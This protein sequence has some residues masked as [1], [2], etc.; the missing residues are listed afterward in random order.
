MN[1]L[2]IYQKSFDTPDYSNSE[3]YQYY[4]VLSILQNKY[5]KN[6]TFSVIDIGSG[7]GQL[8]SAISMHFPNSVITSVDLKKFHNCNVNEFIT[9]DLSKESD[10]DK[11]QG[12]YDILIC[13]DVFEHLDKCFIQD[14]IYL[15]ARLSS[16]CILAIANHSDI[17]NGIELHT[18]QECSDWWDVL[19][20]K[21]FNIDKYDMFYQNRLYIYEC[22]SFI[23]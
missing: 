17:I 22:S 5:D 3:H 12:K 23:L 15:C 10:R 6:D 18:I 16:T 21:Y 2:D 7:R 4:H 8:I 20:K 13:T 14:V 9:C 11:I 19:I 1:Y